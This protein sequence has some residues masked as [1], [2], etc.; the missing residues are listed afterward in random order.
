MLSRQ[1][2]DQTIRVQIRSITSIADGTR[3]VIGSGSLHVMLFPPGTE[4][5]VALIHACRG[6]TVGARSSQHG[7]DLAFENRTPAP[8]VYV[9]GMLGESTKVAGRQ[10][11]NYI[12]TISTVIVAFCREVPDEARAYFVPGRKLEMP[13]SG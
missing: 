13:R 6:L 5:K 3:G 10:L 9:L 7:E 12:T 4:Q 8:W 2:Q 11:Q 1:R